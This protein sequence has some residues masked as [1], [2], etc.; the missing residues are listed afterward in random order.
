MHRVKHIQGS[1]TKKKPE[2]N[3]HC[4]NRGTKDI[5]DISICMIEITVLKKLQ[6]ISKKEIPLSV[7]WVKEGVGS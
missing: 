2:L 3:G 7:F 5:V 4:P 6:K 1:P